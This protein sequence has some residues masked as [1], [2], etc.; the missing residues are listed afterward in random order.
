M[1]AGT[2][3]W[4]STTWPICLSALASRQP[5]HKTVASSR[6]QALS[7][8]TRRMWASFFVTKTRFHS[9]IALLSIKSFSHVSIAPKTMASESSS[10]KALLQVFWDLA[11]I[12]SGTKCAATTTMLASLSQQQAAHV[13]SADSLLCPNLEYTFTRLIT[14]LSSSRKSARQGFGMALV[15]CLR[16]F[17][18]VLSTSLYLDRVKTLIDPS[19]VQ[20]V[21][22]SQTVVSNVPPFSFRPCFSYRRRSRFKTSATR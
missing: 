13:T 3:E 9:F 4:S 1:G 17:P 12:D 6:P 22:A 7:F 14:G 10:D 11:E 18:E 20:H 19:Q 15:E 2:K 21:N 16:A 8:F 5:R